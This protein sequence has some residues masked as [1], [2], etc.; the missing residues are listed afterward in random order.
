MSQK[1]KDLTTRIKSERKYLVLAII[2]LVLFL[3]IVFSVTTGPSGKR[4]VATKKKGEDLTSTLAQKEAYQ[5]IITRF[6]TDLQ[7]LRDESKVARQETQELKKSMKEYE[8]RTA[9]I[10]QTIIKNMN[11]QGPSGPKAVDV[12]D[13]SNQDQSGSSIDT[14]LSEQELESFGPDQK[15][16]APP[17]QPAPQKV[18]FIGAGDSVRVKLLAG[19]NAPT[20]GTP[21]PVVFKLLSDVYGPDGSMLPLG[22]ARL[23]AAAQGSLTDSRALFRLTSL[24]IRLPDGRRKV[25][26][27][28]GWI[29]GEDGIRGM[30]GVL[31]DPIGK[32]IGGTAF[33]G[34][35][36]GAGE[37]IA[38]AN[39]TVRTDLDSGAS[40][41]A[42]TGDIGSYAAGK[43]ASSAA[44]E[45]SSIIRDRLSE[46]VPVVQVLSG[47][48][49]TAVFA[50]NLTVSGLYEALEDE[51]SSASALD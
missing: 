17:P 41:V 26:R 5:D 42:I 32:A 10:F 23:I 46:M 43:G 44:R 16:V 3:A 27:A 36:Q 12:P 33:A 34:A 30:S 28:D 9:A 31:I 50:K 37:G 19:V 29:V 20:D 48:E 40:T 51:D 38:A 8:E 11:Q 25:L 47:R 24:N 21:Y 35:L 1:L 2:G 39:S 18:A 45:W 49:A 4:K 22:E 13:A 6:N 7:G 15:Q 14:S